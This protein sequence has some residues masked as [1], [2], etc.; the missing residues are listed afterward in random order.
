[1]TLP[2]TCKAGT[3]IEETILDLDLDDILSDDED[4]RIETP[5]ALCGLFAALVETPDGA[6]IWT[7]FCKFEDSCL[8]VTDTDPTDK[9]ALDR[10]VV[11]LVRHG[12]QKLDTV[13]GNLTSLNNWLR[14][15]DETLRN[16]PV[17]VGVNE[18]IYAF[19]GSGNLPVPE[20]GLWS[21]TSGAGGIPC[22]TSDY[23]WENGSFDDWLALWKECVE[24]YCWMADDDNSLTISPEPPV[25]GLPSPKGTL[26][27]R[28]P[29][30]YQLYAPSDM[31]SEDELLELYDQLERL[32]RN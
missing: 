28:V 3:V 20:Y 9:E 22:L 24:S 18:T 31:C 21:Y 13:S 29:F 7:V 10:L 12:T 19:T 14:A 17:Q 8:A 6:S 2:L 26:Q 1:M 11:D 27:G 23:D 15:A 25:I 4:G 32:E 5:P 30:G 16:K